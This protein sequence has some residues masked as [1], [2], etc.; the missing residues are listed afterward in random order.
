LLSLR[1]LL[2]H[3]HLDHALLGHGAHALA[4][5]RN[6]PEATFS[7]AVFGWG[8]K[9]KKSRG[10]CCCSTRCRAVF[11]L[12]IFYFVVIILRCTRERTLKQLC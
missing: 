5:V 2:R 3:H 7:R 11:L 12:F 9:Y 4:N 8:A 10:V 6:G 1:L